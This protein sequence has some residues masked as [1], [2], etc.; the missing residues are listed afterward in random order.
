MPQKILNID[1]NIQNI[2]GFLHKSSLPFMLLKINSKV[3]VF[4]KQQE[5]LNAFRVATAIEKLNSMTF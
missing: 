5:Q 1:L 4:Q 2:R 3:S